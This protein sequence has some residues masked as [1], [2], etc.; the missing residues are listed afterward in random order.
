MSLQKV[1]VIQFLFYQ[2]MFGLHT[3]SHH[4]DIRGKTV[5]SGLE[6]GPSGYET[7]V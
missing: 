1:A 3:G 2:H 6:H 7:S 5:V 4:R